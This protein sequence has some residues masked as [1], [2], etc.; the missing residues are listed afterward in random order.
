MTGP[1]TGY[2]VLDFSNELGRS[3]GDDLRGRGIVG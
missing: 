2:R 3:D 1:L